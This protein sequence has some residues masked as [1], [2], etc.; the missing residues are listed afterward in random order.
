MIH[1][2]GVH[3]VY[4]N[5]VHALKDVDLRIEKGEFVYLVGASGAGKST[6]LRLFLREELPTRGQVMVGGRSVVRLRRSEV[7]LLRRNIGMVFQDFRLLPDRTV[8][9]NVAFVLEVLE[10]PRR[11]I[12][13]RVTRVLQQVGLSDKA[14]SFPLQ[15]A[16]GEQQRV[17]IARAIVN[18]P[19][20]LLA[21]E[22]TGNLDPHASWEVM[23]ILTELNKNGTTVVIATHAQEIVNTLRQRVVTLER[24]RVTKDEQRGAY[25]V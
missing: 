25:A 10:V 3:K 5:G 20:L 23:N 15:L 22:P 13:Y 7:N 24:G 9:E 6:L 14:N 16:G 11:D 8:A 18:N 2:H 19:R 21:D 12:R 17:G 1:L 4:L